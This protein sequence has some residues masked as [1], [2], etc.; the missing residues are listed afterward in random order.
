MSLAD[1]WCVRGLLVVIQQE[2]AVAQEVEQ[3]I[4]QSEG[5]YFDQVSLGK[6]PNPE[7]VLIRSLE[8]E[9]V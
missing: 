8:C 5:R 3:V 2:A 1:S 7:L 4:Y 6:K 9:C